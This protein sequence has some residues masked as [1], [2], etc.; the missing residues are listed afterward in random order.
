MSTATTPAPSLGLHSPIAWVGRAALGSVAFLGGAALLA[1][2]AVRSIFH[3]KRPAPALVPAVFWQLGRALS[4]GLALTALVHVGLGSFLTMQ[5]YFGGTFVDGAGAVVG[6]G[7]I[8]NVAPLMSGLTL[9]ALLAA[10][11]TPELRARLRNT[12]ADDPEARPDAGRLALPRLVAGT[13][14]GP[15]LA[16]WG[17]AVGSLVGWAVA[18]SLLGISAT[19]FWEMFREMLWVRDV[20]GLLVKGMGFGFFGA[21]FAC[22]EGLRGPL[23]DEA[24]ADPDAVQWAVFRAVCVSALAILL[25]NSTWFVL[26]YRAGPAFGPTLLAPPNS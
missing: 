7:L 6:V 14:A 1:M 10:R 3:T 24:D 9:A 2:G 17:A 19:T 21:L 8:R 12:P 15:V 5:S 22:L 25:I 11:L 20:V 13:V 4:M 26:A 16:L 23:G 18:A